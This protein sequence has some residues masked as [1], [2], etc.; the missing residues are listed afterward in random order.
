MDKHIMLALA[1]KIIL[2][3]CQPKNDEKNLP[4]GIAKNGEKVISLV[5]D[6]RANIDYIRRGEYFT[7]EQYHLD[8]YR[9]KERPSC[10]DPYLGENATPWYSTKDFALVNDISLSIVSFLDEFDTYLN[11]KL[12]EIKQEVQGYKPITVLN[13]WSKRTDY[14]TYTKDYIQFINSFSKRL[15]EIIGWSCQKNHKIPWDNLSDSIF[16]QIIEEAYH[17]WKIV[18]IQMEKKISKQLDTVFPYNFLTRDVVTRPFVMKKF[19]TD[20]SDLMYNTFCKCIIEFHIV[21]NLCNKL[22]EI[23]AKQLLYQE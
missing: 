2:S 16:D 18:T 6:N 5:N 11:K 4:K 19:S 17:Q 20:Y 21:D 14:E 12:S 23:L 10:Y 9:F 22:A 7:V 13:V 3:N 1:K 15:E 8:V